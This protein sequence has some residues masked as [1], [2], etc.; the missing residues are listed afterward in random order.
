MIWIYS[1][2]HLF[3][4][5]LI[6]HNNT[7]EQGTKPAV[8]PIRCPREQCCGTV[9]CCLG[10]LA[11]FHVSG[12]SPSGCCCYNSTKVENSILKCY[13]LHK[14]Y[15]VFMNPLLYCHNSSDLHSSGS[16]VN[17]RTEA[18]LACN[19]ISFIFLLSFSLLVWWNSLSLG[20]LPW[21]PTCKSKVI[22]SLL[23]T[24]CISTAA[25]ARAVKLSVNTDPRPWGDPRSSIF[26]PT[27]QLTDSN[28]DTYWV[29]VK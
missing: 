22:L 25:E 6:T 4:F 18:S 13:C 1:T 8:A 10:L 26:R 9:S 14:T 28:D 20:C 7:L 15:L 16:A 24:C 21:T 5:V 17:T 19:F 29:T 23:P 12:L 11:S 2:V 3:S 27:C